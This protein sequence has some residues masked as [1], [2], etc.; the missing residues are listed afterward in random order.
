MGLGAVVLTAADDTQAASVPYV[1]HVVPANGGGVDRC[2]RDI[3]AWRATDCILHVVDGQ[4][5]LEVVADTRFI[6]I[7]LAQLDRAG[8]ERSFGRPALLHAHSTLA[9]ARGLVVQLCA[10]LR[11]GYVLTLHD[12]DFAAS[13]A[14]IPAAERD[15][16]LQFV[17][18]AA[19]RIAPS[20]Y[21]AGVLANVLGRDVSCDVIAN[22]VDCA[23]DTNDT[24]IV[25]PD[26]NPFQVAVVGALGPHKGLNFLLDAVTA[27]PDDVR[28]VI[29][30][31]VDGQLLPGWLPD[32]RVWLHGAFEPAELAGIVRRYGCRLALFPNR[33]A[34]SYCYAL[35]DV[36]CA[37]LPALG[38]ACGA[39][40]ERISDTGA[41]WTFAAQASASEVAAM[42]PACLRVTGDLLPA[43]RLAVT[44][45][46]SCHEMVTGLN[47]HY[48]SAG[49][50]GAMPPEPSA[51]QS[52]AATQLNGKFFR[53]ELRRLGGDLKFAQ[54]Q[55]AKAQE[56]L[57]SLAREYQGRGEWIA[58]LQSHL[59]AAKVEIGRIETARAAEHAAHVHDVDKLS[60]DVTDTLAAAH[61]YERALAALPRFFRRWLLR[62]AD[63][64]EDHKGQP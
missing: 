63:R 37:G 27:L 19:A 38:P 52:L 3:C 12:T 51:L 8:F 9:P 28:V 48:Q 50:G 32:G 13:S 61:R 29:L 20:R 14:D 64:I 30:G 57:Q 26:A 47:Q 31:Y 15:A 53:A 18:A 41:G 21:I 24:D 44:Q 11:V 4:V 1:L 23:S 17:G 42:I 40:G 45:L 59:D 58:T 16:R 36:W 22:G 46:L 35:S 54:D 62:R 49:Q 34:E 6:P 10:A 2:V 43:V 39:I 7:D 56:S 5:V 25:P 55:A 60:R 33:Q